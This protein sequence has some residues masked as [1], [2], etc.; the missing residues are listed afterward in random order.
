MWG[1]SAE[2]DQ[3]GQ[4]GIG[5]LIVFI[6]MVLVAAIAA[7]VLINTAD[8]LQSQSE[9]TG[10]ESTAEVSNTLN[11]HS[12]IAD[13]DNGDIQEV[14][15]SVGL[16]PGSGPI[17][18]ENIVIDYNGPNGQQYIEVDEDII[19]GNDGTVLESGADRGT[20]TIEDIDG[21]LEA[22]DDAT[23]MFAINDGGQT[24]V[25]WNVPT[26]IDDDDDG[27]VHL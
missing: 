17:D 9:A 7:G 13:L 2:N 19:D 6:A 21:D 12:S 14:E 24:T 26:V 1:R 3:R 4:V 8:Q 18:L 27:D 25:E 22:G 15:I 10:Q 5:T 23:L 16:A 20:I 11:V